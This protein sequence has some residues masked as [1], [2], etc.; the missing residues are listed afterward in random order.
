MSST[1]TRARTS[2]SPESSADRALRL[3]KERAS[4]AEKRADLA[5]V[6]AAD[7]ERRV[8]DKDAHIQMLQDELVHYTTLSTTASATAHASARAASRELGYRGAAASAS[9]GSSTARDSTIRQLAERLRRG[10]LHADRHAK[11]LE[12]RAERAEARAAKA[13]KLLTAASRTARGAG[14]GETGKAAAAFERERFFRLAEDLEAL[15][16]FVARAHGV[17]HG[18]V[19]DGGDAYE[20][21][22]RSAR[23]EV[24]GRCAYE[25]GD[26][27]VGEWRDGKPHGFGECR[28]FETGCA[29]E[30][31]WREGGY[32][33]PGKYTYRT[34]ETFE[35]AWENDRR[36]GPGV[37]RDAAGTKTRAETY[38]RG[39]PTSS[40]DAAGD[41]AGENDASSADAR[42]S[43]AGEAEMRAIA[44]VASR[45][46]RR[47][48]AIVRGNV[49]AQ[50]GRE[51]DRLA[52][53]ALA[54]GGRAARAGGPGGSDF[55]RRREA[56]GGAETAVRGGDQAVASGQVGGETPR[57]ARAR[58][59][60]MAE[61][62]NVFRRVDAEKQKAGL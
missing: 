49:P 43:A 39:E 8:K 18:S 54:S 20:G 37:F 29:Y 42:R 17:C 57:A 1:Q 45:P 16:A 50:R 3:A 25:C 55:R 31:F 53:R 44:R 32:H 15:R 7:L 30:G 14:R 34:G 33:G 19:T 24:F 40:G 5:T 12:D 9:G 60:I 61:V 28:F 10:E 6:R 26:V 11:A 22:L 48:V 51:D 59:Q 52:R 47:A 62:T 4:T 38:V 56:R 35:G 23:P 41:D 36:H 13:E 27:Y 58:D 21:F 46:V 2:L